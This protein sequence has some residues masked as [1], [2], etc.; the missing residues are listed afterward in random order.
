M[1]RLLILPRQGEPEDYTADFEAIAAM[2]RQSD[3]S[4]E[5]I[6]HWPDEGELRPG[7]PMPTMIVAL[8]HLHGPLPVPGRLFGCLP[9]P[10][11][12]Q[13]QAYRK[14]WIATPRATPFFWGIDL[15]PVEWGPFVV[16]KPLNPALTSHGGAVWFPTALLAT[17]RRE[18]F[19]AD[20]P[21]L[22]HK[23]MV[24]TFIDTGRHPRH[25]RVLCL[26]GTPLYTMRVELKT[27]RPPVTSSLQ[28]IVSS[29]IAT[30]ASVPKTRVM[31]DEPEIAA[32]A[33]Q[34]SFALPDVPLQGI[35]ILRETKTGK[36]YAL[37][38]NPGGNTW[39]F[40]SAFG[41]VLRDEVGQGREKMLAQRDALPLAAR[42]L[43]EAT[44]SY[45]R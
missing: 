29:N 28:A 30:N 20:H 15:N 4:I 35:D 41:A 36:L 42:T 3:P 5:V 26:F 25:Y 8:R 11:T 32:F 21:I 7:P 6:V 17:L 33:R 2:I 34:V 37:E 1:R 44:R 23:F 24:Q 27:A 40:S 18:H 13:E 31:V 39:H 14:N 38:S 19:T 12:E 9:V 22:R 43:A 10:K 16:I 45:A